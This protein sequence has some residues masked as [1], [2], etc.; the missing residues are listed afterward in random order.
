MTVAIPLAFVIAKLSDREVPGDEIRDMAALVTGFPSRNRNRTTFD[1]YVVGIAA[2][3]AVNSSLAS[4]ILTITDDEMPSQVA[5]IIAVPISD[6]GCR[7]TVATPLLFV[8][9][10][11][12]DIVPSVVV[13]AT[14][15]LDTGFPLSRIVAE[16]SDFI[17]E[18][19]AIVPGVAVTAREH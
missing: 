9:A 4:P 1:S 11:G 2:G 17:V 3:F 8:V 13:N 7:M 16:T 10:V 18:S 19:A 12:L 6:S 5:V 15:T 14:I